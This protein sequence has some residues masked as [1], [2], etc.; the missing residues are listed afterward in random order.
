MSLS[1]VLSDLQELLAEPIFTIGST[2]TTLGR[3][4]VVVAVLLVTFGLARLVRRST[5]RHFEKHDAGD[6]VAAKSTANIIAVV[7]LLVGLEIALHLLGLRLTTLFAAGGLFALGA[8]LAA[9]NIVENFLSGVI[10]RVDKTIRTGDVIEVHDRWLRIDRLG[11][12]NTFGTTAKGEEVMIPNATVAQSIVT[13]LTY[14]NRLYRVETSIN[15]SY[16]ADLAEVRKVLED[17]LANLEWRSRERP[18]T[19]FL[20]E[21][22]RFNVIYDVLVWIDEVE[23]ATERKSDLNEALWASLKEAGIEMPSA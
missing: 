2:Q 4:L 20:A 19:V 14:Q 10:L 11:V 6:D 9:K 1:Q 8:G 17:T 3:A 18:P 23:T 21:F 16:S 7:V 12:R 5:L 13:S 15:V 22:T